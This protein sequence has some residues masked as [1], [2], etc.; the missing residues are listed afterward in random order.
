VFTGAVLAL[1]PTVL[2]SLDD[3]NL[4]PAV[5]TKSTA[6]THEVSLDRR[7]GLKESILQLRGSARGWD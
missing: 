1:L 6:S 2:R 7:S 4:G 3:G 5:G